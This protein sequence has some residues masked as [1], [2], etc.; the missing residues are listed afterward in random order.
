MVWKIGLLKQFKA[1]DL[2]RVGEDS[3]EEL[4]DEED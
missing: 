2:E 3:K 4:D 1:C